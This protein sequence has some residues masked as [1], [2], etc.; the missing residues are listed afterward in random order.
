VLDLVYSRKAQWVN[1]IEVVPT[2]GKTGLMAGQPY[3]VAG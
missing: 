1:L 2:S 3:D